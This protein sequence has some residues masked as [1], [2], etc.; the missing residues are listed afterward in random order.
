M[1]KMKLNLMA[2][3]TVI[4][5]GGAFGTK[6]AQAQSSQLYWF[7]NATGTFDGLRTHA[8]EKT[9]SG[10]PDTNSNEC[11]AGYTQDQL[12]NPSNP[13]AGLKVGA[14]P[15]DRVLKP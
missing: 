1:K 6:I 11:R 3:A 8:S 9:I 10:C 14:I 2:I 13:A 4:A 12:I 5:L 7:N 15:S